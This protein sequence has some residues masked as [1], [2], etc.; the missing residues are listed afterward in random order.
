MGNGKRR[1][2]AREVLVTGATGRIG[3]AV[4]ALLDRDYGLRPRVLVRDVD[5]AR[6]VLVDGVR[7]HT[8][9]FGDPDALDAAMDG[10]DA[11]LLVSPVHPEQRTLQGNV[12]RA[13]AA[14]GRP[15]VLKISGL[16]TALDSYIDSG[17]W[18]AQTEADIATLGLPFT[19]LRPH[20]FMQNL[21][22]AFDVARRDGVVRAAVGDSRIAMIDV[23]DIAAVAA[24]LLVGEVDLTGQAVTLTGDVA[25]TYTDVARQ[26]SE[27]LGREVVYRRQT[28]EA[29]RAVLEK[30]DQPA[31][32]VEILIQFNRAFRDGW[33][34][35]VTT[36]IQD[37]VGRPPR[38]LAVYL[39]DALSAGEPTTDAN[40]FPS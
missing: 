11:V 8:G 12:A 15:Y 9:D 14:A 3:R 39:T 17:R 27:A 22:F 1:V 21:A 23:A 36:V 34:E 4:T 10:V 28:I 25:L 35:E 33:G 7:F 20:F 6:D 2:T 31:W 5:R 32:H 30:S 24:K 37:V 13:A 18:H 26:L 29:A 16:G 19:F 38:S 40:P